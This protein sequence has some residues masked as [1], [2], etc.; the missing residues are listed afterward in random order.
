LPGFFY[1]RVADGVV[2]WVQGAGL[3]N[4]EEIDKKPIA[5]RVA[6]R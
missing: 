3:K 4:T 2:L 5:G 6:E 1:G